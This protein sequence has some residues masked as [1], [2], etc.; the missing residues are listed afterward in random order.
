MKLKLTAQKTSRVYLEEK[1]DAWWYENASGIEVYIKS[2]TGELL[3]CRIL[4]K[5][6]LDW[7]NRTTE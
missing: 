3:S 7:I 5:N 1:Y 2:K 4:R 6:I